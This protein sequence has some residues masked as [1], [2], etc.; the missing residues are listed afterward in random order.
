M[1]GLFNR[2]QDEIDAREQQKGLSPIDLLDLPT[3]LAAVI[4]KIVRKHGMSLPQ[5]AKELDQSLEKT[6]KILDELVEK[7][8]VRR[9]EVKEEIWDKAH[10]G[11]KAERKLSLGV[12]S[13]LDGL[14][15]QEEK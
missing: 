12:W 1:R 4:K 6:Q 7:S 9:V 8:Y 5:I 15:E 10:F 13:A 14:M 2:L 11:R 3:E